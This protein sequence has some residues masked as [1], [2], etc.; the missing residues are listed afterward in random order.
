MERAPCLPRRP[1]DC[2]RAARL[3]QLTV[4]LELVQ[5]RAV[6]AEDRE[7]HRVTDKPDRTS[8][9]LFATGRRQERR[10]AS[11]GTRRDWVMPA[12]GQPRVGVESHALGGAGHVDKPYTK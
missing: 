6:L 9:G 3:A 2:G 12:R 1:V 7:R 4:P 5:A 10:E 11:G 8:V